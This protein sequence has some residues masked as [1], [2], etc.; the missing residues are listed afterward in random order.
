MTK[1]REVLFAMARMTPPFFFGG[2]EKSNL[3]LA[4]R[5][6]AA[7]QVNTVF[8]GSH[9]HF[10]RNFSQLAHYLEYLHSSGIPHCVSDDDELSYAYRG[11]KC[12]MVA[13]NV[14]L[15]KLREHLVE[16]RYDVVVTMLELA[17]EIIALCNELGLP[18]ILWIMDSF[19]L[20]TQPLANHAKVDH[21]VFSS[22][23]LQ[24]EMSERFGCLGTVLYPLFDF[25]WYRS[26]KRTPQSITMINPIPEKGY[27]IFVQ[28]AKRLTGRQFLAVEGWRPVDLSLL[29]NMTYLSRQDD[30]RDVYARTRILLVPSVWPE[31]F[32]RVIVEASVNS[33]PVIASKVGGIE[34]ALGD[35]GILIDDVRDIDAWVESIELL[36]NPQTYQRYGELAVANAKRFSKDWSGQFLGLVP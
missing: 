34:E 36:D 2:A 23:Y 5:L 31:A 30:M 20:G 4:L 15:K 22:E 25:D 6:Q 9:T 35:S 11:I 16:N 18:V 17:T 32:G 24:R 10:Q 14:Y 8:F 26:G 29:P 27:D 28:I 1:Q 13:K 19:E 33:I 7:H 21:I 12:Q 3:T